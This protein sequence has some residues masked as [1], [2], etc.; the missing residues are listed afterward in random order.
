MTD[1]NRELS[2]RDIETLNRN[3]HWHQIGKRTV[4]VFLV[5]L[6]M[7]AQRSAE[8]QSGTGLNFTF[9]AVRKLDDDYALSSDDVI[10]LHDMLS[11]K[12]RE[13]PRSILGLTSLCRSA[14]ERAISYAKETGRQDLSLLATGELLQMFE[15]LYHKLIALMTF[16]FVPHILNRVL[17]EVIIEYLST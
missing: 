1:N 7:D 16:G 10:S 12:A 11:R 15:L 3:I 14:C 13:H 5:Y 6:T 4:P 2:C 8:F 17:E 9:K